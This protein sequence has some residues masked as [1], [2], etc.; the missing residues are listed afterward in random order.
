[1]VVWT[2][3]DAPT[4]PRHGPVAKVRR[5]K[6]RARHRYRQSIQLQRSVRVR[7]GPGALAE[8]HHEHQVHRAIQPNHRLESTSQRLSE[9]GNCVRAIIWNE[10]NDLFLVATS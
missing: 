5:L 6:L 1:M 8:L 2:I 9:P 10:G 3:V 7:H 4:R